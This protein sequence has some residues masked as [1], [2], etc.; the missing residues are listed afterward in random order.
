MLVYCATGAHFRPKIL[1]MSLGTRSIVIIENSF[2]FVDYRSYI[3][4]HT[5]V[6]RNLVHLLCAQ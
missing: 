4:D 5:F 1:L 2:C 6:H 3:S